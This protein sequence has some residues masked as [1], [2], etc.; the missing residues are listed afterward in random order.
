M[1]EE[2]VKAQ[3]WWGKESKLRMHRKLGHLDDG[4]D[5]D[6]KFIIVTAN[7][8]EQFEQIIEALMTAN[9]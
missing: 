8:I 5:K 4:K 9:H 3:D 2:Y 1:Q 6:S 7:D